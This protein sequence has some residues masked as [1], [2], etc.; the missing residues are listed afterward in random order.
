VYALH[1]CSPTGMELLNLLRTSP[2]WFRDNDVTIIDVGLLPR[3]IVTANRMM[4]V[5]TSPESAEA[6]KQLLPEIRATLSTDELEWLEAGNFVELESFSPQKLIQILN[7][8]IANSRTL[9]SDNSSLIF[10]DDTGSSL[11]VTESFG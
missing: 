5:Q 3:Q 8:S 6:A 1:D 4:F 10:I 11:Y 9:N 7:Q 2:Q